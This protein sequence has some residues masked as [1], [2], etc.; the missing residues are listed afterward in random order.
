KQAFIP[1]KSGKVIPAD[2]A[3]NGAAN[4]SV[5]IIHT[6]QPFSVEDQRVKQGNDGQMMLELITRSIDEGS[7]VSQAIERNFNTNRR[8]RG[9]Y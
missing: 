7:T 1:N 3:S 9:G 4:I 2:K 8:A 6:G 5:T